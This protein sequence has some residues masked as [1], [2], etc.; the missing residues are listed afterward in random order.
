MS[1]Y[2]EKIIGYLEITGES[3]NNVMSIQN[4]TIHDEM[5][6]QK[7]V[8][9]LKCKISSHMRYDVYKSR[10]KGLL[11]AIFFGAGRLGV[12][13]FEVESQQIM[14]YGYRKLSQLNILLHNFSISKN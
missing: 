10:Y 12:H 7:I 5:P 9:E 14:R 8:G 13:R 6:A 2:N 3:Q 11:N 1:I 4:V